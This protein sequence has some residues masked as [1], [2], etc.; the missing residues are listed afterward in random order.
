MSVGPPSVN[1]LVP[2]PLGEPG[3]GGVTGTAEDTLGRRFPLKV[4]RFGGAVKSLLF[5]LLLKCKP[6][7]RILHFY[8]V[9][10]D[11]LDNILRYH[12]SIK[13]GNL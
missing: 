12:E 13:V 7:K 2:D 8:K 3:W 5:L 9:P 6:I 10:I 4:P 11:F 1:Q